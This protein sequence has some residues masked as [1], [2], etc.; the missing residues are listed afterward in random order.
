MI[1]RITPRFAGLRFADLI[2]VEIVTVRPRAIA[3]HAICVAALFLLFIIVRQLSIISL[4]I[5]DTS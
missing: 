1:V 4:S 2:A 3:R 5:T